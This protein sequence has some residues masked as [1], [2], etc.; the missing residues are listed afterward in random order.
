MVKRREIIER[1]EGQTDTIAF[2]AGC[3]GAEAAYSI[4]GDLVRSGMLLVTK[5]SY[6]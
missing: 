5:E 3:F 6:L 2:G 4:K 1:V